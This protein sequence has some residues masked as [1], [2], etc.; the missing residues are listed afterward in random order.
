MRVTPLHQPTT[1]T[2][3]HSHP[4]RGPKTRK[5]EGGTRPRKGK[6][7]GGTNARKG[8]FEW[9]TR[10][11]KGKFE[12]MRRDLATGKNWCRESHK[13]TEKFIRAGREE[14]ADLRAII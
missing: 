7:E 4:Q 5:F 8:K 13:R 14:V 2:S 11:R 9:G 3:P 1:L 10:P 12:V 6:C